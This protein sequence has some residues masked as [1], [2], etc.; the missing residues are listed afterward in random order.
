MFTG[1]L[2]GADGVPQSAGA[3][4]L[5]ED[6][7]EIKIHGFNE[8]TSATGAVRHVGALLLSGIPRQRSACLP[9]QTVP[10]PSASSP[11]PASMAFSFPAS[12]PTSRRGLWRGAGRGGPPQTPVVGVWHPLAAG[13][14][15]PQSLLSFSCWAT[16]NVP[17]KLPSLEQGPA[18]TH[19]NVQ[20]YSFA[21][22][23]INISSSRCLTVH[24]RSLS[25][26]NHISAP[27]GD[28][29]ARPPSSH[30]RGKILFV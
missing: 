1:A 16:G 30:D 7:S 3:G 15:P 8:A 29:T 2:S 10:K 13:L 14:V 22:S 20:N 25:T 19:T 11:G 27:T 12:I 17:G 26:V 28:Q 18:P 6:L 24:G 23:L 9:C 4:R 21:L 5:A